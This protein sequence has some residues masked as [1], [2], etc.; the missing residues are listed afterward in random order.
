MLA[1]CAACAVCACGVR[2]AV[3]MGCRTSSMVEENG[4]GD[5]KVGAD[6]NLNFT[7][8][9]VDPKWQELED[10]LGIGRRQLFVLTKSWKA[11]QRNLAE[12]GV[13]MF[14]L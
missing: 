9:V 3:D 14:L 12:T 2:V 11:V 1:Q 13:E 10:R 6:N 8:E 7:N 5:G 4:G